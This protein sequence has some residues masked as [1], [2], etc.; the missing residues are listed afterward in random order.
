MDP[1]SAF[2][3]NPDCADR[4][5]KDKGNIKIHSH[6]ERRFRCATCKKTFAATTGTPFFRLH[7][8]Q[9]LLLCVITLLSHGCPLPA[10]VAALIE[11]LRAATSLQRLGLAG[12]AAGCDRE[13]ADDA[14]Q[15]SMDVHGCSPCRASERRRR[16][17]A[18]ARG[19][20]RV[21]SIVP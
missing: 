5:V 18:Y 10:V 7:K 2:C 13:A 21:R 9:S 15:G 11:S 19:D 3:A 1:Q 6:K 8:D 16:A 12:A 4:G 14:N 20:L 17:D